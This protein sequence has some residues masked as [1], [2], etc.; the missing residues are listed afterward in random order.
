MPE[1]PLADRTIG[2]VAR[3]SADA[4]VSSRE[5]GPGV[6]RPASSATPE[7]ED[8]PVGRGRAGCEAADDADGREGGRDERPLLGI[9]YVFKDI[10]VTPS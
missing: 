3:C 4:E 1:P 8:L 7:A 2:E 5:T 6:P 9:P 10:F